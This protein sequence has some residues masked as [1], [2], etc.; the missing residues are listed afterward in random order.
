MRTV[1]RMCLFVSVFLIAQASTVPSIT[2]AQSQTENVVIQGLS[3]EVSL[4]T[5]ANL[6][7]IV[8]SFTS[9]VPLNATSNQIVFVLHGTPATFPPAWSGPARVLVSA[10]FL[11]VAPGQSSNGSR[12]WAFKFAET[13]V[14][15]A[16]INW[17]LDQ[18]IIYG[19]AR[20]G[21]TTPLTADQITAL[22]ATGS[23]KPVAKTATETALNAAISRLEAPQV[24]SSGVAQAADGGCTSGGTGAT[25]CGAGSGGCN[26]TCGSGYYA[27][28]NATTNNCDCR[29]ANQLP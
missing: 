1:R 3:G 5:N 19:I 16:V 17:T 8:V 26:V 29:L 25:A 7:Q 22:S 18:Y 13:P 23:Y 15:P 9:S 12:G 10:G 21:E 24:G 6:G 28:C 11:I 2:K 4:T 14:P 20:Y 27:C